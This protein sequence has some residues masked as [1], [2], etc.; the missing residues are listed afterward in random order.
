MDMPNFDS[1]GMYRILTLIM[2][3][4]WNAC[5]NERLKSLL[6]LA[7]CR[8]TKIGQRIFKYSDIQYTSLTLDKKLNSLIYRT[9]FYANIY[10]SYKLLKTV[11]FFWPI[12]YHQQ[13]QI[14]N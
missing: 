6:F 2:N 10:E 11:R 14:Q 12:L 5:K 1:T 8:Y 9:L 13:L 3:F 4:K 7:Q